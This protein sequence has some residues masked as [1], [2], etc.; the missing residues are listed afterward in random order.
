MNGDQADTDND[1]IGL[2]FLSKQ[3]QS[4]ALLISCTNIIKTLNGRIFKQQ[5][6][7]Q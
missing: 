1:G 6:M 4:K 5:L 7:Q 2:F 3:I